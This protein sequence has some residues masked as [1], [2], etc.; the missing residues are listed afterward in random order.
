[1]TPQFAKGHITGT[2]DAIELIEALKELHGP[3]A[4]FHPGGACEGTET[5]CLTRAE[6]LPDPD[7]VRLGEVAGAPAY[8]NDRQY[9]RWGRPE[10]VI[11]VADGPAGGIRLEGLGE[12]HFVTRVAGGVARGV[13]SGVTAR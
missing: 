2:P 8:V 11:D 5:V 12:R 1:M 6:L 3:V 10:L 13:T 4:F 7:D 9:E